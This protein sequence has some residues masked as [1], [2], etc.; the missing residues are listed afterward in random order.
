MS[1]VGIFRGFLG[2]LPFP[3][4]HPTNISTFN[5]SSH[6]MSFHILYRRL[7][8]WRRWSAFDV[9]ETTYG[10]ENELWRRWSDGRVGEWR[11]SWSDGRGLKDE[12]LLILQLPSLHLRHSSFS[13]PSVPSPTSQLILLILLPFHRFTYVIAYSPNLLSLHVHH[14]T[15]SPWHSHSFIHSF[16]PC[17][18]SPH[19]WLRKYSLMQPDVYAC[20]FVGDEASHILSISGQELPIRWSYKGSSYSWPLVYSVKPDGP[21][22]T[23]YL[24]DCEYSPFGK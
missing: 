15:S 3:H 10:L 19:S 4:S 11:R 7:A 23:T 24:L 18:P 2:V 5:P 22:D 20:W 6:F 14:L 21:G 8:R 1:N 17:H 16:I 12:A 13:N 9:G